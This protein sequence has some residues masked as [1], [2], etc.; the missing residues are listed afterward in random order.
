MH[1]AKIETSYVVLAAFWQTPFKTESC[2]DV[3]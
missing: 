3:H 2:Y 1:V